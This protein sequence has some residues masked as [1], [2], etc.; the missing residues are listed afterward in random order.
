MIRCRIDPRTGCRFTLQWGLRHFMCTRLV[1]VG[2]ADLSSMGMP[3]VR[4]RTLQS[5]AEA[6]SANSH[7]FRRGETIGQTVDRLSAIKGLGPWTAHVAGPTSFLISH[8]PARI[9]PQSFFW[10]FD[11]HRFASHHPNNHLGDISRVVS[12]TF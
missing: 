8:H 9:E 12:N 5:V 6:A 4:V 10:P 11:W 2:A 3:Y 1:R 7:F